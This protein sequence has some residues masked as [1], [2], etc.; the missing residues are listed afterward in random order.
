MSEHNQLITTTDEVQHFFEACLKLNEMKC[1]IGDKRK[2][3]GECPFY[4]VGGNCRKCKLVELEA[5]RILSAWTVMLKPPPQKPFGSSSEFAS[6]LPHD[7][8]KPSHHFLRQILDF[9]QGVEAFQIQKYLGK[10]FQSLQALRWQSQEQLIGKINLLAQLWWK[11][12]FSLKFL[13]WKNLLKKIQMRI[14]TIN[15]QNLTKSGGALQRHLHQT[16]LLFL[17]GVL[18]VSQLFCAGQSWFLVSLFAGCGVTT[19]T[20]LQG[21]FSFNL[22]TRRSV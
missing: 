14:E 21:G 11:S 13:L 8:K 18:I 6:D 16:F 4:F 3:S 12:S 5:M 19:F 17:F 9:V 1:P 10:N 2:A 22:F 20:L 7:Q 15:N